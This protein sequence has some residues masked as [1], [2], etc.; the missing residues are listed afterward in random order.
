MAQQLVLFELIKQQLDTVKTELVCDVEALAEVSEFVVTKSPQR[1]GRKDDRV[2]R[3]TTG[4]DATGR[5]FRVNGLRIPRGLLAG[6]LS[7]GDG[8]DQRHQGQR[9]SE[10]KES[11][12]TGVHGL[13]PYVAIV[14]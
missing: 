12:A 2:T 13:L 10:R 7:L 4:A 5:T 14:G 1:I 11:A 6:C 3:P 8:L 9:R